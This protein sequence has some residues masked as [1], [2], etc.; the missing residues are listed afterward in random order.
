[1]RDFFRLLWTGKEP[2]GDVGL[3]QLALPLGMGFGLAE[4]ITHMVL[5]RLNVLDNVWYPIIWISAVFNGILLSLLA[6]GA[7]VILWI[8]KGRPRLRRL[9]VFLLVLAACLPFVAL[10][11]K[12]WVHRYAIAILLVG[13]SS[14][15]TRWMMEQWSTAGRWLR[16]SVWPLIFL[17][18]ASCFTIEGGAWLSEAIA[19]QN[20]PKARGDAPNVLLVIIDAL[21][22]DHLSAYGYDR[23][24]TPEIDKLARE[25]VLFEHAYSTS[26]YTLPSHASILTG[27]YPSEHGI[28]WRTSK[29]AGATTT[30]LPQVL[31]RYGY[32]TGAFS[33]NTFWFSREH[34]FGRGFLHFEDYFHSIADR[35]LR[36]SYGRIASGTVLGWLGYKDISARKHA[37]DINASVMDWIARDPDKPFF[38]AINYMDVHDPYLPPEPY[39]SKFAAGGQTPGGRINWQWHV[40]EC[41]LPK[42]SGVK[43]PPTMGRFPMWITI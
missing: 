26:S 37:I 29:S 27:L 17:T 5:Q 42:R 19:S 23:G 40:P 38:A 21:R 16:G 8:F 36:T 6:V 18:I 32:R 43:S 28:E 13:I 3:M 31:T 11:L 34:G 7:A 4:G 15:A 24:T 1:M 20:L 33:G 12:E 9:M 39:R 10:A 30:T 41:S 2:D 22:A 35:V 25:G 14:L